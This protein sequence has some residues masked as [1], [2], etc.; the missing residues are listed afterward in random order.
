MARLEGGSKNPDRVRP[1]LVAEPPGGSGWATLGHG[2]C[3][4]QE[5]PDGAAAAW[6][7]D[8]EV[9]MEGVRPA[10]RQGG[11]RADSKLFVATPGGKDRRRKG[12]SGAVA[13]S[14]CDASYGKARGGNPRRK[15]DRRVASENAKKIAETT[16][17]AA[18]CTG[19]SRAAVCPGDDDSGSIGPSGPRRRNLKPQARGNKGR[20]R[21][22]NK[23]MEPPWKKG[24]L[25]LLRREPT[26][27]T[28]V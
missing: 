19:P 14:R 7:C 12:P 26:W 25:I 4:R 15:G 22:G 24:G 28:V 23:P 5:V 21:A 18:G 9:D 2:D 17:S 8:A 20:T 16:S 13:T 3:A 6:R 27:M 10:R 11:R 1:A